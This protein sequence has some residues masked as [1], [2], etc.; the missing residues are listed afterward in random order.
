M[1]LGDV[2]TITNTGI[3][4][5]EH[6]IQA[7]ATHTFDIDVVFRNDESGTDSYWIHNP[8]KD[9][10]QGWSA[11]VTAAD[12]GS[13]WLVA[14]DIAN[15]DVWKIT[16]CAEA[17]EDLTTS[18]NSSNWNGRSFAIYPFP[19]DGVLLEAYQSEGSTEGEWPEGEYEFAQSWVYEGNQESKLEKLL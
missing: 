15:D 14:Y 9:N 5:G 12:T 6:E 1:S 11:G 7:V 4:N 8:T 13:R 19:G 18:T 3:Y 16:A 10:F 2:V 17:T